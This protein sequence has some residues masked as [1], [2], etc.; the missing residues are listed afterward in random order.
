MRINVC[1]QAIKLVALLTLV[2][3]LLV[4][5]PAQG[6]ET[7]NRSLRL[8]NGG[9]SETTTHELSFDYVTASSIGSIQV[10]YCSN[11]PLFGVVCTPS[12]G[13]DMTSA[14]LSS[15]SG[16][17][18]FVV[19][20]ATTASRLVLSRPASLVTPGAASYLISNV[21]NPDV[22]GTHYVRV[23][24]FAGIDGTGPMT[25]RGGMAIS[26]NQPLD[27]GAFV[28]PVLL[29]CL[30]TSIPT[31]DCSSATGSN[32]D[33]GQLATSSASF[34]T[35]QMLAATNGVG[36]YT[37]SVYGTT[38]TSGNNV[39]PAIAPQAPSQPG[40]S[41]FG[42]NLV[43]NSDP[44]IGSV[45]TGPGFGAAATLYNSQNLFRFVSGEVIA[46]SNLS[47]DIN[48][49]TTSYIVNIDPDQAPGVYATTL[50]FIA[51]ASF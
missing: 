23:A 22:T 28:P 26:I 47:T 45:T 44:N 13:M 33:F 6:A 7:L 35:T 39:I 50:T 20:G 31:N 42:L 24:T 37:V 17:T 29:F 32:I 2:A 3:P 16:E 14:I 18:G 38:M 49:F 30:G 21:T 12:T 1:K 51:L 19:D 40:T 48:K 15:E 11:T 46:R 9:P 8:G 41:Q 34:G 27:I 43:D 25:D 5:K 10:E 4:S 36:G